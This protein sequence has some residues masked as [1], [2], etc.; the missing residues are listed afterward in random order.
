[1]TI[2]VESYAHTISSIY[3][4]RSWR[5]TK[6]LRAVGSLGRAFRNFIQG[7]ALRVYL[8]LPLSSKQKTRLKDFLFDHFDF[9]FHGLT[10]YQ[11]WLN[12]KKQETSQ[13]IQPSLSEA[14]LSKSEPK[15]KVDENNQ[16]PKTVR[17]LNDK[18][19]KNPIDLQGVWDFFG[20]EKIKS[21]PTSDC[22]DIII[23]VGPDPGNVEKCIQSIK[24]YTDPDRYK[25]HLVVHERNIEN[26]TTEITTHARI[27]QHSMEHFNFSRANNMVLAECNGDAVLLNDDTEVTSNWLEE[28]KRDSKGVMLTGAHTGKQCS[29]NPEMWGKGSAKFTHYPINMFCAFIPQRVR[30]VVGL[31]DEEFNYYGGEDVDYSGRAQKAGFPLM[32]SSAYVHHKGDRSF[33]ELKAPAYAGI[34]Q[35]VI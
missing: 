10:E 1:M 32:V 4:S 20:F 29:G 25:L 9:I 34:G 30:E 2:Q 3:A 22:T 13:I 21:L 8:A 17:G 35:N 6:P 31:L 14:M 7:L 23:C 27:V 16:P 28:L 24:K 12:T 5:I 15:N 33:G 11:I 26:L 19:E 18:L